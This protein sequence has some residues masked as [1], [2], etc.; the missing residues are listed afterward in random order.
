MGIYENLGKEGVVR[1]VVLFRCPVCKR[2]VKREDSVIT[3]RRKE[4]VRAQRLGI[5][6]RMF[7]LCRDCYYNLVKEEVRDVVISS[8]LPV[9]PIERMLKFGLRIKEGG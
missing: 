5:R 1:K 8:G 6:P 7:R 3:A 4:E 2:T 9:D